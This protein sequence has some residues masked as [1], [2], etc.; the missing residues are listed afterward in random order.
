MNQTGKNTKTALTYN[1]ERQMIAFNP[2]RH[3]RTHRCSE[4]HHREATKEQPEIERYNAP[5]EASWLSNFNDAK[6]PKTSILRTLLVL[7]CDT[8]PHMF[9]LHRSPTRRTLP[10]ESMILTNNTSLTFGLLE[11]EETSSFPCACNK[12]YRCKDLLQLWPRLIQPV[13]SQMPP[14]DMSASTPCT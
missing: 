13:L 12:P 14:P 8:C 7:P 6:E 9:M 1:K 3:S 5:L 2:V 11:K 10:T 4:Q